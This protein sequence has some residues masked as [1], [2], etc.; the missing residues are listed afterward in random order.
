MLGKDAS[1]EKI[2]LYSNELQVTAD[3][4]PT[5]LMHATNDDGVPVKNSIL[6]Y[7]ALLKNKVK[8]ELHLFQAGGHGFG[9][10][11]PKTKARWF[12]WCRDWLAA[13]GFLDK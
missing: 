4:P 9:L 8:T 12:D 10:V 11:N 2:D 3:T 13:N 6:M 7:E 1:K 5:F